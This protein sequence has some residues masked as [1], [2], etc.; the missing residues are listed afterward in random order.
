MT[1]GQSI[2]AARDALYDL[3]S[4]IGPA[5]RG[6]ETDVGDDPHSPRSSRISERRIVGLLRKRR[7]G[8]ALRTPPTVCKPG[9]RVEQL[10]VR[11]GVREQKGRAV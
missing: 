3:V 10:T 1:Y 2:T 4:V 7:A 8:I 11:S 6:A 9:W 5:L